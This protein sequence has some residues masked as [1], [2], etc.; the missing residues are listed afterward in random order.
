[1]LPITLNASRS[2]TLDGKCRP[3][4]AVGV[5]D[6]TPNFNVDLICGRWKCAYL[7]CIVEVSKM[8]TANQ[9]LRGYG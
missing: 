6:V 4:S 7:G 1:M 3:H 5:E 8:F 2:V 9:D